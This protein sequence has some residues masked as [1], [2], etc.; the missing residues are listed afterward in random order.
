MPNARQACGYSVLEVLFASGLIVT[1]AAIAVPNVL[2]GLDE[3]RAAGA[4]R[5]MS[6]RLQRAR[7]EAVMRSRAVAVSFKR[8]STGQYT[9]TVYVDGNRTGILASDIARNVDVDI[10]PPESLADTFAGID[11]GVLPGVAAA[12]SG[13]PP[14]G[15]DPIRLGGSN[16]VT[17][18]PRGTASSGSLYLRGRRA[19]YVIRIF[20]E[21]GKTRVL[22]FDAATKQWK[23]L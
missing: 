15:E 6:V 10:G 14:P 5:Y 4:A 3:Y 18:T 21:T 17:F 11:F 9:F 20:G 1:L 16:S 2:A 12:E 22:R 19:Q 23:P 13:S 8:L 7:M